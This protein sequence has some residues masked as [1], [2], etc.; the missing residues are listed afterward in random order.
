MLLNALLRSYLAVGCYGPAE[1]LRSKAQLP[2]ASQQS[3]G[4]LCRYLFYLGRIKAVTLAYSEAKDCLQQ[5]ERK[6]PPASAAAGGGAARGF[7]LAVL[8]WLTVTRLLLGEIPDRSTF[9]AEGPGAAA[10][11]A[12]Y[13][14]L[15]QAVRL[16]D[17][18]AF[19]AVSARHAAR[20]GADGTLHLVGRLRSSVLR[21][22][23]RRVS[24]AY[25]RISLADV[26]AKLELPSA[27]DAEAVAAKAI[28][29]G[30]IEAVL[31]HAQG[32]LSCRG[33]A[34]VYA[35]AEP[36]AAFHARISFCLDTHNEAVQA[37]RYPDARPGAKGGAEAE[38]A[39]RERVAAE[40]SLAEM[41]EEEDEF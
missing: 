21:A 17:L 26:A 5:A 23:L 15:T 30:A 2:P 19:A 8:R 16:G 40:A 32:T 25:S 27:A 36:L 38:E 18:G 4:Q 7:R 37:M 14:E 11:L 13:A 34:D 10:A 20:F 33:A 35:T 6:A 31:D 29:D 39:R 28:A 24:L 22:G 1:Q 9:S 3:N 12:P 41:D